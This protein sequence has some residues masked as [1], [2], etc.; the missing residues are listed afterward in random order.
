MHVVC[1]QRRRNE[2]G[3]VAS[4]GQRQQRDERLRGVL[5]QH[6]LHAC[7]DWVM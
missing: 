3:P 7:E 6:K 1:R 2:E 4:R 5:G